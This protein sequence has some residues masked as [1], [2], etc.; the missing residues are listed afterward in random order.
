MAKK[1]T[2]EYEIHYFDEDSDL[3]ALVTEKGQALVEE[4]REAAHAN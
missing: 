4:I 1:K 2:A 3:M